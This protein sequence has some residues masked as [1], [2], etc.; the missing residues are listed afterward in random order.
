MELHA[1]LHK[2]H[3]TIGHGVFFQHIDMYVVALL[4]N[5]QAYTFLLTS[6]LKFTFI[7]TGIN[8]INLNMRQ[9]DFLQSWLGVFMARR[10]GCLKTD[11]SCISG[12]PEPG[13]QQLTSWSTCNIHAAY[14]WHQQILGLGRQEIPKIKAETLMREN[15]G[16]LGKRVFYWLL[17]AINRY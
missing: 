17:V 2:V 8:M 11:A 14:H 3:T 7:N 5:I 15:T 6:W 16:Q 13:K 10:I 1:D 4:V 9:A 12:A